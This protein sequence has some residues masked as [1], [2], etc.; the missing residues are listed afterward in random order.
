MYNILVIDDE[1]SILTALKF[2]LEDHFKVYATPNV[3]EG[4]E[5]INSKNIDLV[6]LDQYLG[7]YRGI[8]VL[9]TIKNYSDKKYEF[10]SKFCI[11][12]VCLM[13]W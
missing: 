8:E 12:V 1:V 3:L 13:D 9:N 5:M 4:L 7:D 6:L 2:A 11:P 10:V